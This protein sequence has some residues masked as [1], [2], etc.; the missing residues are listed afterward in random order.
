M[1]VP[2]IAID[3][4]QKAYRKAWRVQQVLA[5]RGVTLTVEPG[6]A[7][8]FIGA[9]GAGKTTT[10]K[11]LMGL[12]QPTQGRAALFGTPISNPA[13]RLRLGYVPENPYL[14]D[15]LTPIEVL[16]M[17]VSLHG[18][19]VSSVDAHCRHW[20]E[21]LGLGAVAGKPLRSFSKGMTQRV[22][23]AQALS[24]EPRLLILDEPL[25]GLDPL[26]RRDVVEI[27]SEYKR[28]GGT[29]FLTSHV[30]HDVERLADRFGLI[31]EGILRA[32]RSPAD[33]TGD[34]EQ[35]LVRTF[36]PVAVAGMREDFAGRW[37]GE[38]PRSDLWVHLERLRAAGHVLLEIRP[39]LSLEVAFIRAI[40]QSDQLPPA[41]TSEPR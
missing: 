26:G 12:I 25:S 20:L 19:K 2:A 24:I 27:L 17:S 14:Y 5:L 41:P 32:V 35:V 31:H 11:I 16:R 37:V 13:A 22:A 28:A 6:E 36:G 7:F 21:R 40:G 29:L 10:I 34:Q 1:T 39:S 23:L 3:N 38:V 8:G 15:Y 9:N 30:L 18:L 33:L 4:L